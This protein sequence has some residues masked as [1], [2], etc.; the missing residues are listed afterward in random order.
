MEK[1]V[2]HRGLA[3]ADNHHLVSAIRFGYAPGVSTV[4]AR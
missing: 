2:R 3:N 1:A 4:T